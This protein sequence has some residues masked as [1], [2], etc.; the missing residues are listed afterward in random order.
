MVKWSPESEKLMRIPPSRVLTLVDRLTEMKH[1]G[2]PIM[3][4]VASMQPWIKHFSGQI[5]QN[6]E[7]CRVPLRNLSILP[8]G[9]VLLCQSHLT[10]LGNIATSDAGDMWRSE[11]GKSER[12]RITKQCKKFCTGTSTVRRSLGDYI[13]LFKRLA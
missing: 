13:E 4:S 9:D 7:P 8:N 3:N 1:N 2:Y 11:L 6:L 12:L 10:P 5:P